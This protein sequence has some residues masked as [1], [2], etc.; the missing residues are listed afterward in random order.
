M[1]NRQHVPVKRLRDCEL[2]TVVTIKNFGGNRLVFV[3]HDDE[4]GYLYRK[5]NDERWV[6]MASL[7][8]EVE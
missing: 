4:Y 7:L 8:C 5:L 6:L 3:R 1:T 2:G